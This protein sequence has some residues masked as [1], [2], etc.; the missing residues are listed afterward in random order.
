MAVLYIYS[1]QAQYDR[2]HHD[3]RDW[4]Q[5]NARTRETGALLEAMGF[6]ADYRDAADFGLLAS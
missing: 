1:S 4:R 5:V 2:L 6:D 3:G